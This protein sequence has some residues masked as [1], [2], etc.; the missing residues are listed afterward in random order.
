M[1]IEIFG[2]NINNEQDFHDQLA[3]ALNVSQYYGRNLNALWDLL[4][5]SIERPIRLIWFD[6]LESKYKLGDVFE[7]IISI[8]DRVQSQDEKFGWVDKF[9]YTI[10]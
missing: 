10:K 2:K 6:S 8:L 7:K 5:V 1:D 3:K 4:S 9:T